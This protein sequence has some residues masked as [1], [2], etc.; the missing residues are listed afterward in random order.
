MTVCHVHVMYTCIYILY[1]Y[2][3]MCVTTDVC[4]NTR[5][6][7]LHVLIYISAII[8]VPLHY[9]TLTHDPNVY[10]MQYLGITITFVFDFDFSVIF[11]DACCQI[12][13]FHWRYFPFRLLVSLQIQF[14][15]FF[16]RCYCYC[17]CYCC[18][19]YCI[20]CCYWDRVVPLFYKS[21]FLL[22]V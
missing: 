1:I 19:C 15:S 5:V 21:F 12:C 10:I 16:F 9:T 4:T 13:F 8:R 17:Y 14:S 20:C 2:T 11:A 22:F 7:T 3:C 18:C 6:H